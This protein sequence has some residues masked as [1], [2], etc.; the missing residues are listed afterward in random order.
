MWWVYGLRKSRLKNLI[1]FQF[2]KLQLAMKVY[3]Q[4]C[5]EK[6]ALGKSF[7]VMAQQY[8]IHT[9]PLAY[10]SLRSVAPVL[11]PLAPGPGGHHGTWPFAFFRRLNVVPLGVGSIGS[12]CPRTFVSLFVLLLTAPQPC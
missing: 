5:G 10:E 9:G 12:V 4:I 2:H 7:L 3:K 11:C 8:C 1:Y 6:V